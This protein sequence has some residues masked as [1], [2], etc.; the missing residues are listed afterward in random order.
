MKKSE[1]LS[2][3]EE[4]VISYYMN[5]YGRLTLICKAIYGMDLCKLNGKIIAIEPIN[6]G[7]IKLVFRSDIEID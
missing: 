1:I 3:L 7:E 5:E 6:S 2:I 4:N